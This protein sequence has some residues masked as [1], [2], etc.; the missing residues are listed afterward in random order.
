MAAWSLT[1]PHAAVFAPSLR[2]VR[3]PESGF[4]GAA[5]FARWWRQSE[6]P[7]WNRLRELT[8]PD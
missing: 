8:E 1:R 7:L 3:F 4:N 6:F 2:Y 5:S